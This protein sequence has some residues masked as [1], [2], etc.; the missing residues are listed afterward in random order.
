[1]LRFSWPLGGKLRR[2]VGDTGAMS[3][4]A[5]LANLITLGARDFPALR[6]F[7]RRL[8]W[9]QVMDSEDFAA[10][11]LRGV[12]LALFPLSQLAADGRC[13]PDLGSG[14]IRFSIGIT[15][16]TAEAVDEL[17]GKMRRAGARVTKEPVNA[18]FFNGRSA[19]LADPEDNFFEIVWAQDANP[20]SAAVRRSAGL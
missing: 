10:F 17:A 12:V 5:P 4:H 14:G 11:E 16:D 6:D 9:P 7:Y 20:V 18:E 2:S 15:V 1:M 19:Y 3:E 8:G 13:E